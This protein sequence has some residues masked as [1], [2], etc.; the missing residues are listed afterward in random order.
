MAASDVQTEVLIQELSQIIQNARV[1]A[2]RG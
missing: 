2:V 1:W